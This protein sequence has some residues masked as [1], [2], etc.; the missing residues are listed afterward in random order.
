MVIQH[1]DGIYISSDFT[2]VQMVFMVG[3]TQLW[4][5][6]TCRNAADAFVDV[7]YFF[8]LPQADKV[9]ATSD[10][11]FVNMVIIGAGYRRFPLSD[12]PLEWITFKRRL[13]P[14]TVMGLEG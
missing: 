1:Y 12:W 5:K 9:K 2:N 3:R 7:S 10:L 6:I 11:N 14:K 8:S 13:Y 4:P